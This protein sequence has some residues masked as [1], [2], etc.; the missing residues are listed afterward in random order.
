MKAH[1]ATPDGTQDFLLAR[2]FLF[3]V[4]LYVF[5]NAQLQQQDYEYCFPI[6]QPFLV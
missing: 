4:S 3:V 5:S 6:Q 1:R 2:Y